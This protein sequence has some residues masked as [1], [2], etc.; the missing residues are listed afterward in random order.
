VTIFPPFG[1]PSVFWAGF[2]AHCGYR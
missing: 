1:A 2:D